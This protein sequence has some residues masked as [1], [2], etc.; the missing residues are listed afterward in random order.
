MPIPFLWLGVGLGA[1]A[2]GKHL[3][4]ERS[5]DIVLHHP[6]ES[7]QSAAILNGAVVCCGVFGVF[8]HSGIWMDGSIIELNGNGL[9][10][11]V[12]PQRFLANRSGDKIFVAC[13]A[14][15][16][17]LA[18]LQAGERAVARVFEYSAYDLMR[19]NC[20]Q[21]VLSCLTPGVGHVTLFN[22]LNISVSRHFGQ[23][24]SWRPAFGV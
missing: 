7:Q 6:G 10:R 16:N 18:D 11:A 4:R 12:S 13:D 24:L 9:I 5:R 21:F 1:L 19:N 17:V 20:H 8:D 3:A 2:A 22:E 15:G 14:D 23:S